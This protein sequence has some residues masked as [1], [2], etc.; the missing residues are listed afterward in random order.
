MCPGVHLIESECQVMHGES[1]SASEADSLPPIAKR[2]KK[3]Y[4]QKFNRAWETDPSLKG[5]VS[6][7]KSDPYKSS[8]KTCGKELVAGLSEAQACWYQETPGKYA[9]CF[10]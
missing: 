9:V 5:W 7:V 3:S 2:P 1:A 6:A 4:R 10:K 8:C